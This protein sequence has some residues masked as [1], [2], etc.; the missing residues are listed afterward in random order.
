V[1][2]ASPSRARSVAALYR[3]LLLWRDEQYAK[4]ASTTNGDQKQ[5]MYPIV[6]RVE[7]DNA[8]TTQ[9]D[10][11]TGNDKT[12]FDL[13]KDYNQS[14]DI[15][16]HHRLLIRL[17]QFV[18]SQWLNGGGVP[19]LS[20]WSISNDHLFEKRPRPLTTYSCAGKKLPDTDNC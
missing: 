14:H 18:G 12:F 5:V 13:L 10:R 19:D 6:W 20:K 11:M 9:L 4:H 2:I 16:S 7:N 15:P 17:Q 3:A 1:R 8:K